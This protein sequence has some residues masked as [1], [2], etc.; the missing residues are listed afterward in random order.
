MPHTAKAVVL[1]KENI[2]KV[3]KSWRHLI[4]EIEYLGAIQYAKLGWHKGTRERAEVWES[5]V[6]DWFAF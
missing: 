1:T 3:K 4:Y 2:G 6:S 5:M